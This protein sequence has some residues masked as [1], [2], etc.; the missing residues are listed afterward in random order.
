[1]IDEIEALADHEGKPMGN[2]ALRP[3]ELYPEVRGVSPDL[4]VYF[5]EL[6]WRSV[7]SLGLDSGWY[8]FENDTGP[9]DANHAHDGIF[10]LSS[11]DAAVGPVEDRSLLDVAPTLQTLLRLSA[12]AGQSGQSLV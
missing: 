6:R 5:G 10:V 4:L 2:R 3:E 9:D 11:T 8:T 7:G 12:P 1:L